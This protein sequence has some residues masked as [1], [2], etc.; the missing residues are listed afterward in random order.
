MRRTSEFVEQMSGAF[1]SEASNDSW[2]TPLN[3]LSC[4][5]SPLLPVLGR[6]P[7]RDIINKIR[8]NLTST[9]ARFM[10]LK[11]GFTQV[12]SGF[13]RLNS[14]FTQLIIGVCSVCPQGVKSTYFAHDRDVIALE[15]MTRDL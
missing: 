11:S 12:N 4:F 2:I 7:S 15:V 13:T 8:E 5:F 1:M 3:L 9:S 14:G 10:L 6:I